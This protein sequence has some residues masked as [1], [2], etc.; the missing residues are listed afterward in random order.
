[1]S[2]KTDIVLN[3]LVSSTDAVATAISAGDWQRASELE[4]ERRDLLERYIAAERMA[5]AGSSTCV[6]SS[7]A[8]LS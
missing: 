2:S 4:A 5:M 1:M 3:D 8:S 6:T 7:R